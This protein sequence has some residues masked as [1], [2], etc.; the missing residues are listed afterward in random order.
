MSQINNWS[1]LLGEDR[2]SYVLNYVGDMNRKQTT[3]LRAMLLEHSIDAIDDPQKE[4]YRSVLANTHDYSN[5]AAIHHFIAKSPFWWH[6]REWARFIVGHHRQIPDV[7][8]NLYANFAKHFPHISREDDSRVAIVM[9]NNKA[10]SDLHTTMKIGRYLS[11]QTDAP[12]SAIPD[13]SNAFANRDRT[14]HLEEA[15]TPAEIQWVYENGPTSCMGKTIH[16]AGF[17]CNVHP[18]HAYASPDIKILFV[19][20]LDNPNRVISRTV[21][22]T[23]NNTYVRIFGNESVITKLLSAANISC[24][25]TGGLNNHRLLKITQDFHGVTKHIG[26]YLDS[27]KYPI[28]KDPNDDNYLIIN[29]Q[30]D[31]KTFGDHVGDSEISYSQKGFIDCPP[32][33]K[34]AYCESSFQENQIT[35]YNHSD[36]WACSDC[37]DENMIPVFDRYFE[38]HYVDGN[39]E[40]YSREFI[41]GRRASPFDSHKIVTRQDTLYFLNKEEFEECDYVYYKHETE[42]FI[43]LENAIYIEYAGI[44]VHKSESV[45]PRYSH[46]RYLK[47]DMIK[48]NGEDIP[49]EH[50]KDY[51]FKYTTNNGFNCQDV[52]ENIGDYYFRVVSPLDYETLIITDV[53]ETPRSGLVTLN[54]FWIDRIAR[55]HGFKEYDQTPL[56]SIMQLS[57]TVVCLPDNTDGLLFK[58]NNDL[59]EQIAFANTSYSARQYLTSDDMVGPSAIVADKSRLYKNRAM[60]TKKKKRSVAFSNATSDAARY[61]DRHTTNTGTSSGTTWVDIS[62]TSTGRIRA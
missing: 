11:K 38:N 30:G 46:K 7:S 60:R 27:G 22:S 23:I 40:L 9:D 4:K 51:K 53:S 36:L 6:A 20:A 8:F 57:I 15:R 33:R 16:Q 41:T 62:G 47:E 43:K 35:Y 42:R 24:K 5:T 17:L 25:K 52:V 18:T 14:Y 28:H 1:Q 34:C 45:S 61:T 19:R 44:Y 21:A 26:P 12:E 58:S 50:V 3:A 10:Q 37:R 59:S 54:E 31:H 56:S 49:K 39:A 2:K 48:I 13:I 32:L 55:F 29:P